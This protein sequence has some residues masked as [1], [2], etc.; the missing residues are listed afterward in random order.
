MIEGSFPLVLYK[1]KVDTTVCVRDE[2]NVTFPNPNPKAIRL[3]Q[4]LVSMTPLSRTVCMCQPFYRMCGQLYWYYCHR[5]GGRASVSH[6]TSGGA[7]IISVEALS[8]G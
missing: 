5:S 4:P 1:K 6:V 8:Q 2:C 3:S 7:G